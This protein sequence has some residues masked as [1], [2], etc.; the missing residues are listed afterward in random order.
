MSKLALLGGEKVRVKP[1]PAQLTI[2]NIEKGAIL[3]FLNI[4]HYKGG[5]DIVSR[6]NYPILSGYRGS[7]NKNF[8]G[9]KQVKE[10]EKEF[11]KKFNVKYSVAVNS[12]TSALIVACGAIGLQP[13]DEVIVTP[14]SMTCS[15]TSPLFYGA[16]PVFADVEEDYFC[17]DPE[18]VKRKI[19]E[20]TKAIIVVDLF[21]QPFS[22]E[23]NQIAKDEGLY[24]IEDAAQ[25]IGSYWK[26]KPN[27]DTEEWRNYAGTLGD[28]GCF[29]FTQGKHLT[30]GEGGMIVTDDK[31]LYMKCA[32][33]RNHAESVINDMP[34]DTLPSRQ[35]LSNS[36]NMV[37]FNM[38][39]TELQAVILREQL[40]KLDSYVEMRQ[41]NV[42]KI[43]KELENIPAIEPVPT[44]KD[45][46]HSYYVQGFKW[47]SEKADGLHRDKFIDTVVAELTGEEGREDRPMLGKGYIQPLYLMP[48]FQNKMTDS[49]FKIDVTDGSMPYWIE[50][51]DNYRKG[52]CPTVE[53]LWSDT[54]FLSMYHN[55]PLTDEDIIDIGKAFNK[56][57]EYRRELK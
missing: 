34:N 1:F 25:A 41:E 55:L 50:T 45:C 9:G 28:I 10:L 38:R 49:S 33:I 26:G 16:I 13:G 14:Y 22:E 43:N 18:D 17:L 7:W 42:K 21:G 8:W 52:S 4:T 37:G 29:S 32:L 51:K 2:S 46:T 23:I 27:P 35:A 40:N 57:W 19:T 20:K 39:M 12:C 5:S 15:A 24:I 47:N 11:S 48:L 30:A 3:D 54:F 53:K 44:R 6:Y 31:D 56:V 36:P